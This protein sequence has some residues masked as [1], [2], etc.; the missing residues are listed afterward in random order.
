MA[1]KKT[2]LICFSHLRWN[3]VFQ[4]PQHLMTNLAHEYLIAYVE[5]P[6]FTEQAQSALHITK[7]NEN[8]TVLTPLIPSNTFLKEREN[9]QKSLLEKFIFRNNYTVSVLWYY[10]PMFINWSQ[11]LPHKIIVYDCMDELSAFKNAPVELKS[12]E[13]ELFNQADLVFTGG[14]SLYEAKKAY[15]QAIYPFPSSVD[16]KH[17]IEARKDLADPLDQLQIPHPR[18]GFY[19]VIDERFDSGLLRS[20]AMLRPDWNF[21]I[22]GPIVKIDPAILPERDNI[23]YLGSKLYDELPYY[24]ANWEVALLLFAINEST[25]FISPTK[26][27]EYLA[28]GKPVVSTTI[29]D[30]IRSFGRSKLVHIADPA[31]TIA[32]ISAIEAALNLAKDPLRICKEADR[33]LKGKS[34]SATCAAMQNLMLTIDNKKDAV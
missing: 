8:I 16:V 14:E 12:Y 7:F 18:L 17:F 27:P 4:R 33:I 31:D 24:L 13:K 19:G 1:H 3:F 25:R 22:L 28:A 2:L 15:H 6:I 34:W 9:I 32:F 29:T 23:Y 21:V 20:L 5:E 11:H 30:V 10:S 26:T